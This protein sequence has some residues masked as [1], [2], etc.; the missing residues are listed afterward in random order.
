[1]RLLLSSSRPPSRENPTLSFNL[2]NTLRQHSCVCGSWKVYI[3]CSPKTTGNLKLSAEYFTHIC[4]AHQASRAVPWLYCAHSSQ[5]WPAIAHLMYKILLPVPNPVFQQRGYQYCICISLPVN[6][7]GYTRTSV[8]TENRISIFFHSWCCCFSTSA[9]LPT[10]QHPI[11][12]PC[13]HRYAALTIQR[14]DNI[15][16]LTKQRHSH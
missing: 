11:F 8:M 9:A 1:M 14:T 10:Y 15:L 6:H 7:E 4:R 3:Q 2:F 13:P 12:L 16:Q 5:S